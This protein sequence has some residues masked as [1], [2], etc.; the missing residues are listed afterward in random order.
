VH[1]C[2]VTSQFLEINRYLEERQKHRVN[3]FVLCLSVEYPLAR[4]YTV[5]DVF[6]FL[7]KGKWNRVSLCKGIHSH[8]C[9]FFSWEKASATVYSLRYLEERQKH[10]ANPYV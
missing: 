3:P 4:E 1:D 6:F 9:F 10:R 7:G 2:L 8:R 5:T